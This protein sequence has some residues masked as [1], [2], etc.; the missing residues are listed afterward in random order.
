MAAPPSHTL[1]KPPSH[2]FA[3][4]IAHLVHSLHILTPF[5]ALIGVSQGGAAAL[6]F[7]ALSSFFPNSFPTTKS[8]IASDTSA[9]RPAGN[10]S[11]WEQRASLVFI[12]F[13]TPISFR[14]SGSSIS[15]IHDDHAN[16]DGVCLWL[17]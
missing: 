6:A 17:H 13:G 2:S 11:A 12:V 5:Y 1:K 10:A 14:P 16:H 7:S 8:I 9:V 4:D 3:H 15:T